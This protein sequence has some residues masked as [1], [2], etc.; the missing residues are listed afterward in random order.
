[1]GVKKENNILLSNGGR[2]LIVVGEG[3][4]LKNAKENAYKD[5][6]SINKKEF[7]YRNDISN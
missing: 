1:M 5:F 4:T 3:E 6:E 7:I 2:V